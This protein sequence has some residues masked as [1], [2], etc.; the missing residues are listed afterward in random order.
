MVVPRENCLVR[1]YIQLK[2]LS[3]GGEPVDRS[4]I[5]PEVILG[6][7]RRIIH[8]YTLDYHYIDW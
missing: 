3:V 1:L 6:A 7:A 5:T 2:E 4:T 8:P